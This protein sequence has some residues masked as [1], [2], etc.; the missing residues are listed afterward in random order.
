M[1]PFWNKNVPCS[2]D[3]CKAMWKPPTKGNSFLAGRGLQPDVPP[4]EDKSSS[5]TYDYSSDYGD[6][7]SGGSNGYDR[8]E[9]HEECASFDEFDESCQIDVSVTKSSIKSRI[10]NGAKYVAGSTPWLVAL[11]WKPEKMANL[12]E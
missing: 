10:I 8:P 5:P 11:D 3:V 1:I 7:C 9:C 12:G 6:P 2:E 4:S